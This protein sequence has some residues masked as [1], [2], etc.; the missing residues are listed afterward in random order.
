M[1]LYNA[2]KTHPLAR[3]YSGRGKALSFQAKKTKEEVVEMRK[4]EASHSIYVQGF[5]DETTEDQLKVLFEKAGTIERV[6]MIAGKKVCE[7]I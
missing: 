1:W 3:G 6:N 2:G 4:V 5:A 7:L